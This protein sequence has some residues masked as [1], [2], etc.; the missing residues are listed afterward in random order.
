MALQKE[1]VGAM[2]E[3][4]KDLHVKTTMALKKQA[5]EMR[6]QQDQALE[7][8]TLKAANA[9]QSTPGTKETSSHMYVHL[10]LHASR[11]FL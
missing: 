8:H 7:M 3:I 9:Y 1:H 11:I 6:K 10:R 5:L 4:K 2:A